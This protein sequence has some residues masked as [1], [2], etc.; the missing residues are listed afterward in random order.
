MS[1]HQ[2]QRGLNQLILCPL[3]LM[4][5]V[6]ADVISVPSVNHR[7]S[8]WIDIYKLFFHKLQPRELQFRFNHSFYS[9]LELYLI[10]D[11][12]GFENNTFTK[13]PEI[14]VENGGNKSSNFSSMN[15]KLH[16]SLWVIIQSTQKFAP[17]KT[18]WPMIHSQYLRLCPICSHP[19][20]DH[21]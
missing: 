15:I 13:T 14:P 12:T 18:M 20:V 16:G 9:I 4:M 2:N 6:A 5:L 10:I 3:W 8:T 7:M 19:S 1:N 11:A 17:V 21:R